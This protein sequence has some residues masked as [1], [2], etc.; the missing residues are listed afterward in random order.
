M[1]KENKE[2]ASILPQTGFKVE[3]FHV[4]PEFD[5]REHVLDKECWCSPWIEDFYTDEIVIHHALD[6]RDG[7]RH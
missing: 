7:M 5:V 1:N 6:G 3:I 4:Y 2:G